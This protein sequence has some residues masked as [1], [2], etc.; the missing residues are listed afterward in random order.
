MKRKN[1]LILISLHLIMI[2]IICTLSVVL[3][4]LEIN[5]KWVFISSL[6][7]AVI[8]IGTEF[9]FHSKIRKSTTDKQY[10][11]PNNEVSRKIA[12]IRLWRFLPLHNSNNR[13][14]FVHS[15]IILLHH[16]PDSPNSNSV[17]DKTGD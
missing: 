9:R 8:L 12:E 5:L 2:P 6:I 7:I 3:F 15:I 11:Y 1:R 10:N 17:S 14:P 16:I 13:S 4:A